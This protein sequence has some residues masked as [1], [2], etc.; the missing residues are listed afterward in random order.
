MKYIAKPRVANNT[1]LKEFDTA[2]EAVIYLN[3]QLSAKEGDDERFDYV[4]V[5]PKVS[6]SQ[7]KNSI[8]D[9]M[10]IGKLILVE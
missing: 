4:F 7:L 3:E 2:L 8:E 5:T 9:Y 10:N 6:K 1:G